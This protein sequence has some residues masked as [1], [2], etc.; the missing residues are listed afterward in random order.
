MSVSCVM[1]EVILVKVYDKEIYNRQ[2]SI[3][4][5]VIII[6]VFLI[7]FVA[8][9]LANSFNNAN[10]SNVEN[11]IDKSVIPSVQEGNATTDNNINQINKTST[12]TEKNAK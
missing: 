12:R 5:T 1:K 10:T 6:I 3:K 2:E 8:G 4:T 11:E 9:Y 7:G